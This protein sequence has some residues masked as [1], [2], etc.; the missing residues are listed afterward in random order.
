MRH[1]PEKQISTLRSTVAKIPRDQ[2]FSLQLN[3]TKALVTK[4]QLKPE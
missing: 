1:L 3:R 2:F 4:R